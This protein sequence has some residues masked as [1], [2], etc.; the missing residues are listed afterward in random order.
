MTNRRR[1]QS[2]RHR[3]QFPGRR[4]PGRRKNPGQTHWKKL[5]LDKDVKGK[6]TIISNSPITVGDAWRAF[7]TALDMTNFALIPSGKY[8]R[9]ARQ[10]D[11]R[12][13]QVKTYVGRSSPDTDA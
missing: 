10:R 3:F 1:K 2:D 11:A 13:K 5:H 7:L 6:I 8:I 4:D 12:D 9:I